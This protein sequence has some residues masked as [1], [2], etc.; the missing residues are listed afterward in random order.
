MALL[1]RDAGKKER[2]NWCTKGATSA[3]NAGT[4]FR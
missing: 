2:I 3:S 1:V 4:K